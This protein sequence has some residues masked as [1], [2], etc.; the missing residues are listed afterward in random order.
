MF[1][2]A[3]LFLALA[4]IL[5]VIMAYPL[6]LDG[7]NWIYNYQQ[8]QPQPAI[9]VIQNL[10][11]MFCLAIGVGA[12]IGV[13]YM[14]TKRK[15]MFI[16][17]LTIFLFGIYHLGVI[18][19]AIQETRPFWLDRRISMWDWTCA[20]VFGNPSGHVYAAIFLYGP[21][22]SDAIGFDKYHLLAIPLAIIWVLMPISRM[23]LGLHSSD[24]VLH[25]IV[26]GFSFLLMYKYVLQKYTYKLYMEFLSG[27]LKPVKVALVVFCHAATIVVPIIIFN[28]NV[29]YYPMNQRD[30]DALHDI[31]GL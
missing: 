20:E 11:S 27:P 7:L 18:N 24:Q 16:V 17:H 31:C 13:Y 28:Y 15:L 4:N 10:I 19:M 26:Y 12:T 25:G 23:Y 22:V 6:F 8:S 29:R 1:T 21:I 30:L 14:L 3:A 9:R 2:L 5:N